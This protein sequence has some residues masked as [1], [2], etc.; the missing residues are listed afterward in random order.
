MIKHAV[1]VRG[2]GKNKKQCHGA[3]D[4]HPAEGAPGMKLV[5]WDPDPPGQP[6]KI[7]IFQKQQAAGGI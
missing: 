5:L 2:G 7:S 4:I 1:A 3:S 6:Q